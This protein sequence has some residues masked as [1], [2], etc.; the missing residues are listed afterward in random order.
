MVDDYRILS[1]EDSKQ[2]K[3]QAASVFQ[4]RRPI[5]TKAL[6]AGRWNQLTILSD[7]VNQS[8]L[9]VVIYGERGVGKSSLANVIE[10]VILVLDEQ[11]FPEKSARLVVKVVANSGDSFSSIWERVFGEINWETETPTV[12]LV[13]GVPVTKRVSV[14]ETFGLEGNLRVD[15]VRRVLSQ[16]PDALVIIDEFDRSAAEAGKDF[17]DLLKSLSDFGVRC[18]VVLVGVSDTI[19]TLVSDHASIARALIQINLPRMKVE[20]LREILTNAEKTLRVEF[21]HEASTLIVHISQGLPHYTHL[22]GL[23]AVR[24]AADRYMRRIER[25]DVFGALKDAV[26]QAEQSVKAIHSKA[27]HSSHKDAL[28]R[29]ILLACGVAA[30]QTHDPLGYFNPGDVLEPLSTVLKRPAQFATFNSHLNQFQQPKRSEVLERD[31]EAR[32]YRYR[33]HDPLLVPFVFMDA[34]ANN[35]VTDEQLAG[36]LGSRF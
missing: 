21:S 19:D 2:L 30:A 32:A 6:F 36:M 9:H 14:R 23:Q 8:G 11:R 33:F 29:Q 12:G 17:T 5:T 25:Q 18:T 26:G 16:I 28:Y 7:A 27:V 34:I 31:G 1:F 4:P 20:E 15:D 35:L 10:P 22:I 13:P 3:L 24:R